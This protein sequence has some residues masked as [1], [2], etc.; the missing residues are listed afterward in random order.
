MMVNPNNIYQ[1]HSVPTKRGIKH[2]IS[3]KERLYFDYIKTT[4]DMKWLRD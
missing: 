4:I 2:R 3:G 1:L